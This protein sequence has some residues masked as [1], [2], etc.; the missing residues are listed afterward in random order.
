MN[1]DNYYAEY[2]LWVDDKGVPRIYSGYEDVKT[3]EYEANEGRPNHSEILEQVS[4]MMEEDGFKGIDEGN[5][6]H[7]PKI[8][9]TLAIRDINWGDFETAYL[10]RHRKLQIEYDVPAG[11]LIKEP[12]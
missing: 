12:A 6:Q 4:D 7:E 11:Q 9:Y 1:R 8:V 5:H 2:Y 3:A 10:Q